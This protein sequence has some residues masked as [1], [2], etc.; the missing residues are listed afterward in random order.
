MQHMTRSAS[1]NEMAYIDR[2]TDGSRVFGVYFEFGCAA[3]K[4]A[5]KQTKTIY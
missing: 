2:T 3:Y 5:T 1:F 4:L